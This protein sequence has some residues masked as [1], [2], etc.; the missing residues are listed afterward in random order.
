MAGVRRDTMHIYHLIF[1]EKRAEALSKLSKVVKINDVES[2]IDLFHEQ[3][4]CTAARGR[5]SALFLNLLA[6]AAAKLMHNADAGSQRHALLAAAAE[7]ASAPDKP[8]SAL[9]VDRLKR[10]AK[11]EWAIGC[12]MRGGGGGEGERERG[13]WG[14]GRKVVDAGGLFKLSVM[15]TR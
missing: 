1:R 7:A 13:V 5:N 2:A 8:S 11:A 9:V 6:A 10:V 3:D 14:G 12:A 4:I 15:H